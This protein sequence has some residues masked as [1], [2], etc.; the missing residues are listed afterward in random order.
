MGLIKYKRLQ[1]DVLAKSLSLKDMVIKEESFTKHIKDES[2]YNLISIGD[3]NSLIALSQ[4]YSKP[5]FE[6][7]EDELNFT[8]KVLEQMK[9]NQQQFK[10]SFPFIG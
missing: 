3:F 10:D 1:R 9:E 7:T 4:E 2:P 6:L 5:I 8:G